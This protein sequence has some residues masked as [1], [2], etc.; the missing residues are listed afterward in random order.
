MFWNTTWSIAGQDAHGR[1][2]P[3][4]SI[5][6]PPQQTAVYTLKLTHL[7]IMITIG[8]FSS[9]RIWLRKGFHVKTAGQFI[10]TFG[11][12][13]CIRYI[14]QVMTLPH[15]NDVIMNAMASQITSPGS[16]P[17]FHFLFPWFFPDFPLILPN[18]SLMCFVFITNKCTTNYHVSGDNCFSKYIKDR[19]VDDIPFWAV[20][21]AIIRYLCS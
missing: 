5:A 10:L 20:Y 13:W 15:Y 1:I 14:P 8:M 12:Q 6:I 19:W 11:L 17:D 2:A 3:P 18:I 9:Q 21:Q 7:L 16:P 4:Y